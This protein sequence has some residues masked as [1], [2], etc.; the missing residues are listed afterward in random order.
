VERPWASCA[1]EGV[2]RAHV[3]FDPPWGA[4]RGCLHVDGGVARIARRDALPAVP[5]GDLLQAGPVLVRGGTAVFDRARDP[6]GFSAGAAQ[7]DSDITAE[8]HPRAAIGL[9]AGKILLVACDGRAAGEAGLSLEELATVMARLGCTDALNLDG[10][11]STTLIAGG[12]LRN[13]PRGGFERLE[14]GGRPVSTALLVV[15]RR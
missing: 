7:F 5:R 11:G 12:A 14:P 15:P 8:R 3:P 4:V 6:E 13:V 9:A 1:R 2:A 10:G